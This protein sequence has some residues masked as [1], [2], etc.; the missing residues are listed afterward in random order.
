[1]LCKR[2]IKESA[3]LQKQIQSNIAQFMDI[4]LKELC[5]IINAKHLI[6]ANEL[7]TLTDTHT[8]LTDKERRLRLFE[9]LNTKGPT[10]Y[11]LFTRCLGEEH[12][13]LRHKELF[14]L[15][16][17][18]TNS[19]V[20]WDKENSDVTAILTPEKRSPKCI[21][22]EGGLKTKEYAHIVRSWRGW[23]SNGQWNETERAEYEYMQELDTHV[24]KKPWVVIL[25]GVLQGAIARIMRKHYTEAE[26]LLE[27]C[28]QLCSKVTGNNRVILR[29][30]CMYTWSWLFRYLNK[31]EKAKK[32]AEDALRI[33]FNVEPGEDKALANY[34]YATTVI[35]Y[36]SLTSAN[37]PDQMDLQN[38]ESSL[39]FAIDYATIEDRGLDHIAPHSHLRLAQMY[40]GSTHFEPGKN[41]DP[42]SIRK[43]SECLKAIDRNS[44]PPRTK[45]IFLLTE[46]DF[47]RCKG[48]MC[49]AKA[50]AM[51]ALKIA[52][53]SGF[54]TEITSAKTK[55]E[56]IH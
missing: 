4:T 26:K 12:S 54:E 6:M 50:S 40:L 38:A 11:I 31:T 41:T 7:N 16:C 37:S 25:A 56:S 52:E 34:G 42:E 48:D 36:Q 8:Q 35:D 14:D 43:A 29:G 23:V 28:D 53:A 49:I 32:C 46:S 1:M 19:Q 17:S 9:I 47:Y 55:L 20:V 45:C 10:A 18:C 39:E 22:M 27:K 13:H 5:P 2:E 24:Q 30:R 3:I 33:L 44:L 15:L 51:H 21:E